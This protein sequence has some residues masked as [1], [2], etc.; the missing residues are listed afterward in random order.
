MLDK[1]SKS[2]QGEAV[3]S[4]LVFLGYTVLHDDLSTKHFNILIFIFKD[5]FY[6]NLHFYES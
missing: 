5:I 2:L 6:Y 3:F 4:F 1:L